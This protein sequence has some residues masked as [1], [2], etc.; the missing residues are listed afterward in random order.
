MHCFQSLFRASLCFCRKK[1]ASA[2]LE[3][4]ERLSLS[5]VILFLLLCSAAF[6]S[7]IWIIKSIKRWFCS[8]DKKA[9]VVLLELNVLTWGCWPRTTVSELQL[10]NPTSC[11]ELPAVG[12][13]APSSPVG[14]PCWEGSLVLN[15]GCCGAAS[16]PLLPCSCRHCSSA[17]LFP[18]SLWCLRHWWQ[19]STIFQ[20]WCFGN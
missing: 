15:W 18:F 7:S 19:G 11:C 4:D 5:V 14:R 1:F 9:V 13:G 6:L 12:L 3:Q 2:V 8:T 10:L 20:H 16:A 17:L